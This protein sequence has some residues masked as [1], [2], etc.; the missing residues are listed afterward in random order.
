MLLEV[1][2][3]ARLILQEPAPDVRILT[4]AADVIH[5]AMRYWVPRFDRDVDCRDELFEGIDR[6]L[7]ERGIAPPRQRIEIGGIETLIRGK[8]HDDLRG[9]RHDHAGGQAGAVVAQDPRAVPC[10]LR[11][12]RSGAS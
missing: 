4:Y 6:A 3:N 9:P 7:R 8:G 2:R 5:Y 12:V 11:P 10:R 1:M